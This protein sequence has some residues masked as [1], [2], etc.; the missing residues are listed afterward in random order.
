[1]YLQVGLEGERLRVY[2]EEGLSQMQWRKLEV[3]R[4]ALSWFK[5][6]DK[7]LKS[8]SNLTHFDHQGD[9]IFILAVNF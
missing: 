2:T 1:M 9:Y 7:I 5:V 6:M 3:Q 4:P 8:G